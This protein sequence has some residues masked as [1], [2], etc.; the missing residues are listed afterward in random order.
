MTKAQLAYF[1]TGK[2]PDAAV[3]RQPFRSMLYRTLIAVTSSS[4]LR[5]LDSIMQDFVQKKTLE[6]KLVGKDLN[7]IKRY[8]AHRRRP[9]GKIQ[10]RENI[11][12]DDTFRGRKVAW[13]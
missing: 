5:R 13:V 12:Y 1:P 11:L 4:R 6:R 9:T 8:L 10:G 7:G 2:M 3:D